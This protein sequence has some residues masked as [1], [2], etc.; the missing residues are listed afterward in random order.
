[1]ARFV[2]S[3]GTRLAS[4]NRLATICGIL[5]GAYDIFLNVMEVDHQQAGKYLR[6]L[7]KELG[8][9]FATGS[10]ATEVWKETP[11]ETR[12]RRIEEWC[13]FDTD[14]GFGRL[15]LVKLE[16]E[17][18]GEIRGTIEITDLFV[19]RAEARTEHLW[20]F[21]EGY[22]EGVLFMTYNRPDVHVRQ[23]P[24]F[25]RVPVH[26]ERDGGKHFLTRFEFWADPADSS[27]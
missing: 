11:Y 1:M 8:I 16:E 9:G 15:Q 6:K 19:L 10:L 22:V 7:G 12:R 3:C 4:G 25:R 27:A 2:S 26:H 14:V 21:V 5:G 23:P 18:G 13:R 24:E 17:E 20:P